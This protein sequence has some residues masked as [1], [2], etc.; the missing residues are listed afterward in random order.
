MGV[1]EVKFGFYFARRLLW[2]IPVA[3]VVTLV[4]FIVARVLPGSPVYLRVG[5]AEA[6]PERIEQMT[7]MMGLDKPIWVQYSI[8]LRELLHGDLGDS[9]H[10]LNPVSKD[11]AVRWPATLELTLAALMISI[12]IGVP[13]GVTS[14]VHKGRALDHFGRVVSLAGLSVPPFWVG[15]VLAYLFCYVI[16]VLPPPTGRLD[17][18]VAPPDHITGFYIFDALATGNATVLSSSIQHIILP[19]FVL[20]LNQVAGIARMVRSAMAEVLESDYIRAARA[21][22]IPEAKLIYGYALKNTLIPTITYIGQAAAFLLGGAVIVEIIF[23]WP[24]LGLYAM[25]SIF[26]NDYVGVQGV[27][28]LIAGLTVIIY[29]VVDFLY[30]V[31]DPRVEY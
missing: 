10:T 29:L 14:A 1:R 22:G 28:L 13:L 19:A 7:K 18:G 15:L 21:N 11:L 12:V 16:R 6:T 2:L 23:S 26:S 9:W 27:T 5:V 8:F 31:V 20:G 30:F 24:G 3:M 4:V 25:D 17:I